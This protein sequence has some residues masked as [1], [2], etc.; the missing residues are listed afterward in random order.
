MFNYL[1][2]LSQVYNV[3]SDP[4]LPVVNVG[5]KESPSYLPVEACQVEPGQPANTKLSGE[6]TRYM[7]G[8]AVRPPN[9]NAGSIVKQGKDVLCLEGSTN[10]TLVSISPNLS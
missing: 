6:Q 4:Q 10:P 3:N 9:A 1:T 5:T 8:F 2:D 7:L